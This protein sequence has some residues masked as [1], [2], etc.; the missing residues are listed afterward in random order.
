L[1]AGGCALSWFY[2]IKDVIKYSLFFDVEGVKVFILKNC[3]QVF[4]QE[5]V[6]N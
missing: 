1:K 3:Q 6:T 4:G 5:F 2:P